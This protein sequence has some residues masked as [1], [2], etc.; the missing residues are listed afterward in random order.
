M[1]ARSVKS[2]LVHA[3]AVTVN[4]FLDD[5]RDMAVN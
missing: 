1:T 5:T 3:A 4:S 2:M